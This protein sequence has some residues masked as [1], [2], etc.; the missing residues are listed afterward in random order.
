[1]L[2]EFARTGSITATAHTLHYTHSAVS[3]QLTR[4]EK[5]AGHQLFTKVGRGLELTDAGRVLAGY[6][7]RMTALADEAEGALEETR[8]D[9]TGVLRIASFQTVL[10]RVIP[11][12]LTLLAERYP[13]LVVEISQQEAPQAI[14]MLHA[15]D[16]DMILDE[17]YPGHAAPI[18]TG[19]HRELLATESMFLVVPA[20]FPWSQVETLDDLRDLPFVLDPATTVPGAWARAM[21]RQAG[22]EPQARYV[23]TDPLLFRELVG[24]GHAAAFLPQL[25]MSEELRDQAHMRIIPLSDQPERRLYTTVLSG[26]EDHPAI[27]AM[28]SAIRDALNKSE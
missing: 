27:R 2:R 26:R 1:M 21:C 5:E 20:T 9:I 12:A 7:E 24:E 14:D 8:Q 10:V 19:L 17:D 23:S 15:R 6:A 16:T 11:T 3:Q 13:R 25:M 22:F 18:E 4:L 28:R